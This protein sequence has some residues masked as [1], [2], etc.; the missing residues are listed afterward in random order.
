MKRREKQSGTMCLAL[1][2]I[3]VAHGCG[4]HENKSL[5]AR[6]VKEFQGWAGRIAY[7]PDGKS[8]VSTQFTEGMTVWDVESG[9]PLH[10][11]AGIYGRIAFSRDGRYA[12]SGGKEIV[13]VWEATTWHEVRR[14]EGHVGLVGTIAV[15]PDGDLVLSSSALDPLENKS[16]NPDFRIILWRASTAK[17]LRR[18]IGHVGPVS[19]V[20][21]SPD[22]KS[23]LSVSSDMTMR[24][25]DL[26]TGR[27]LRRTS[28]IRVLDAQTGKELGRR[29]V[30][31][32]ATKE[33]AQGCVSFSPDGRYALRDLTL[34]DVDKWRE[35][36]RYGDGHITA[37]SPDGRRILAGAND[38]TVRLFDVAT[39]QE[40]GGSLLSRTAP[41]SALSLF[42]LMGDTLFPVVGA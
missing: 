10:R 26:A 15:S 5:G 35:V 12:F 33:G 34:W 31:P 9:K 19:S 1:V 22:G 4:S 17:E 20:A 24:L 39:G 21:F 41:R 11:F 23:A 30:E 16:K 32:K 18:L 6:P 25:W 38:G 40:L 29:I 14:F 27:E 8:F 37:F 3:I 42:P 36:R 28:E 2:T 13:T 7:S